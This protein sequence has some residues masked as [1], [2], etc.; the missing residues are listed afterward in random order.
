MMP[1]WAV[2]VLSVGWAVLA[3]VLAIHAAL[4]L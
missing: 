2:V 1:P 3:A 4:H